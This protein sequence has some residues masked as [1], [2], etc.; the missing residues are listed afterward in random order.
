LQQFING[1][2]LGSSCALLGVSVALVWGVLRVLSFAQTQLMTWGAFGSLL[3]LRWDAPV[4]VAV[5]AGIAVAVAIS[6]VIDIA[7][8]NRLRNQQAGEF[9]FVVVTIGVAQV[10]SS[11]A[12]M[13]TENQAVSFPRQGFPVEPLTVFGQNVPRLSVVMMV[14]TLVAMVVLG[15]WLQRTRSGMAVRAVAFDAETA[16]LLGINSR[17]V[18]AT[19]FMVSGGMAAVAG[20]FFAASAAQL[21]HTSNDSLLLVAFAATVI[22]GLGSIPG[23]VIGGLAVGMISVYSTVWV[24][25]AFREAVAMLAIL[26]VLVVRPQG[27]LGAKATE[28]V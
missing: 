24:S 3:A 9:A 1:L 7:L 10:L 11:V 26:V 6:A 16:E 12:A 23:A 15:Y 5:L 25:P 21:S 18:F 17:R 27:I 14:F 28:R 13:R 20:I 4:L 22:G 2:S 19:C 8:F